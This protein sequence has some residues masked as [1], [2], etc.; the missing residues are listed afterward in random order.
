[1]NYHVSLASK[2]AKVPKVQLFKVKSN[3]SLQEN[4]AVTKYDKEPFFEDK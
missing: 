3:T 1:M 4:A 2:P